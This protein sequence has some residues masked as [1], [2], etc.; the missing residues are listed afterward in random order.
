MNNSKLGL[1][2]RCKSHGGYPRAE[3][4]WNVSG[5]E[6]W[7][8]TAKNTETDKL[9]DLES[10]FSTVFINCSSGERSVSC[11]VR[12]SASDTFQVCECVTGSLCPLDRIS[13]FD[14]VLGST[15]VSGKSQHAL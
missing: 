11:S 13:F 3:V 14:D 2:V 12:D 15:E 1:P 6:E 9:T 7:R 10:T 8:V 5:N 4:T